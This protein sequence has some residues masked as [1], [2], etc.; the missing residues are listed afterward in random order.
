MEKPVSRF[1]PRTERGGFTT[2]TADLLSNAKERL[3]ISGLGLER[4]C[5]LPPGARER[6]NGL[7]FVEL[8]FDIGPVS[9][10]AESAPA[11]APTSDEL[12]S[13]L[14]ALRPVIPGGLLPGWVVS[15]GG[16]GAAAPGTGSLGLAL[17]A[18]AAQ[19]GGW[20]AAVGRPDLGVLAAAAMGAAPERLLL[21][22][23]P[24][25]RWPDVVAALIDA[26]D[27][28]LVRPRAR[29]SPALIRRLAALARRGRCVLV[30]DGD[31]SGAQLR[32]DV[33]AA[34]WAGPGAGHGH[35]TSRRAR[36]VASGRGAAGP[37][38]SAWMW[39]PGPDGAV[40]P[41]AAPAAAGRPPLE[42]VA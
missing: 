41:A 15:V 39:L 33:A 10:L 32:L 36:V 20:C 9:V 42:V 30:A 8:M 13:V 19:G 27:L 12:I 23:D 29:P 11:G 18:G 40:S 25:D 21:V 17:I 34:E 22:D 37:G 35:L 7:T 5:G 4:L 26:V 2:W 14:P 38:R 16:R 3:L 1:G 6:V 31:W 28:V 24:G